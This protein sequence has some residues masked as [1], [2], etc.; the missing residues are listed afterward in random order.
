MTQDLQYLLEKINADGVEKA[1]AEAEQIIGAA[2]AQ[3]KAILDA[4]KHEA[5]Q[6]RAVAK[7]DADA[8]SRRAEETVRQAAR[9]TRLSV[10]KSVA[11]MLTTFLHGAVCSTMSDAGVVAPLV[12]EAVRAYLT[13]NEKSGIGEIATS[14]A[15]VE[16][17]RNKLAAAA[18]KDGVLV[19][20]DDRIGSGFKVRIKDGHVEH[21]FTGPAVAAALARG[22]RPRLAALL[23]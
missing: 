22:L 1:K 3:A 4:A 19:V 16:M 20:M 7:Q 13:G 12:D 10:E 14:A 18:A 21:D 8:F 9:D 23:N 17:L 11:N 2:N 6:T 15:L 5:E